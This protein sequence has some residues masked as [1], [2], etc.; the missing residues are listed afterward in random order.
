MKR[1]IVFS[2]I[3]LGI[4][5]IV[6]QLLIIRELIIS[7]YGN[8]FF[9]G[10]I[11]L[12]WLFWVGIG[13]LFLNKFFNKNILKILISCHILVALFIPLQ[14]FLARLSSTLINGPTGQI[15]NLIPAL[16][17]SFLI[18]APLCLILGLQFIIISR[19]WKSFSEKINLNQILGK[20]YV[21]ETLGF[22]IGGLGFSHLLIFLNEFQS[23]SILA[24]LNLLIAG[25][26]LFLIK[27]PYLILKSLIII[28]IIA[29]IGIS[30][31]SNYINNQ[32]NN[33]RF[34]N[35]ELVE[36][37]NSI[38]GNIAVTKL[39]EQY[40][41]YESGLLLGPD[42][43]EI[44]NEYLA[45]FSL[46]YHNNP[47][48]VLLIGNGFNG[49]L[50][51][52]LK[53]QPEQI[54]YLE[55]DPDLIKTIDKYIDLEE[56][57][58][59]NQD[60][61]Y[62]LKNTSERFDVIIIN[63]PNPSTAL[64]NRFYTED[65][66]KET[67]SHLASDGILLTYLYSSPDYFGP[68]IENLD[69]S[70]FKSLKNLFT[71]VLILPEYNH[72]FIAS[73]NEL[74]YDPEILI[75]RLNQRNIETNFVNKAY[76]KYRLTNDRIQ[77]ILSVLN[78]NQ[79]AKINQDQLPISYYYNFVHW[80]STFY[81]N[82]AK[83]FLSLTKIKFIWIIIF[84]ILGLLVF[85]SR[86]FRKK[87]NLLPIIM[88]V[89]GFTLMASELIIIFGFQIFYGYLYYKLAL[90]I[91]ILMTGM[92]LGS[93]LGVK[94]INQA[95]IKTLIQIHGLIIIFSLI[96]LLGFYLLFK[97]SPKPSFIIEIIFLL[98]AGL[99]G[100]L[101]G[102]EFPIINK[103][104]FKNTPKK[105]GVIYGADLIGSCLS[106][107]VVSVFL[108]PIFGIYQTLIFLVILN[109]MI[110]MPLFRLRSAG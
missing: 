90:I 28:L 22:I 77:Q 65:F 35:Q 49:I 54:Y 106:A 86:R 19:F 79:T 20:S 69:A 76:I 97:I 62:F 94:K 31:F 7:F 24:W 80:T 16:L 21:L 8:E 12:S 27:K 101:V 85:L 104:Y 58:I 71:S 107:F 29:F 15:P 63:L 95:K 110:I 88:A 17:Y 14:I 11:F 38:Y 30:I 43:E 46:L 4:S 73:E 68:E 5:S 83:F 2:L 105:A 59:I 47:K 96:L 100:G 57:E 34:P 75:E 87:Q 51:E 53:H 93:W 52:I 81:P 40:N 9:I 26:I 3:I 23:I 102:F 56:A 10:W 48:K 41:F 60:A 18:I 55:L 70:L 66:I 1:A 45:H 92:A 74:N 25:Y 61:R 84:T 50:N 72:L 91:T 36:S 42:K 32:T 44:F 13:S 98:G 39:K 103:L 109:F 64:I 37:K 78:Q 67:K 82:L 33:F 89:A 108:V 99:I 6:G